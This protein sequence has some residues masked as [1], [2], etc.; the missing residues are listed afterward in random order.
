VTPLNKAYAERL[1]REVFAAAE[2]RGATALETRRM[3]R[4]R[5]AS[6]TV[7]RSLWYAAAIRIAGCLLLDL[8][9]FRQPTLLDRGPR[10]RRSRRKKPHVAT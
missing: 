7:S 6:L 1:V 9:D 10:L 8:P 2:T 3:L 5:L 4:A